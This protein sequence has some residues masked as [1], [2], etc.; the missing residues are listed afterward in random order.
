MEGLEASA[1]AL[2]TSH[3][4]GRP[5]HVVDMLIEERARKL[6]SNPIAWWM[7]RTFLYPALHY[8]DALMMADKIAPLSGRE[9]FD[10]VG[11]LLAMRLEVE[12][13][14]HVPRDGPLCA[15]FESPNGDRRWP[16][17]L[18]GIEG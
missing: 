5:P 10:Y 16:R 12:G 3:D 4:H 1:N 7:I 6:R 11:E 14:E 18:S 17:T 13:L 15:G 2:P 8:R 9:T